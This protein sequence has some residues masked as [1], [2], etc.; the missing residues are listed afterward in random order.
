MPVKILFIC[1]GNTCRSPL[2]EGLLRQMA[3]QQNLSVEVK[4][5]GISAMQGAPI[6]PHSRTILQRKGIAWTHS[7][8]PATADLIQ[9]ADIVLT[10]T[11]SHKSIVIQK[12]PQELEKIHS[13]KEFVEND[14]HVLAAISESESLYSELEVR[15]VF[16]Q[17]I[18]IEER[19]RLMELEQSLPNYD[20]VDP[21][22]GTLTEYEQCATEIEQS[23]QKLVDKIKQ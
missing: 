16:S 14:P 11:T 22:G 2:A 23:L 5:A 9:W 10:M 19:R 15:K 12:H 18:T 21:F 17:T 20:I 4:S 3:E 7:S 1:T 6:S 13:L 8:Q